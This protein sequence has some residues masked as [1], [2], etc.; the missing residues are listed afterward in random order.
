MRKRQT[1]QADNIETDRTNF[2]NTFVIN[3]IDKPLQN[4]TS[5]K[6]RKAF[7]D[8]ENLTQIQIAYQNEITKPENKH[9]QQFTSSGELVMP[10][11]ILGAVA[12]SDTGATDTNVAT[13][14]K[15]YD[16]FNKLE[17]KLIK[18]AVKDYKYCQGA[19]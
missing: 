1:E 17:D 3:N 16:T 19:D 10:Q 14:E 13:A 15:Y 7:L 2:N 4:L 8:P 12:K 5:V 9:L 6:D 11:E 18:T